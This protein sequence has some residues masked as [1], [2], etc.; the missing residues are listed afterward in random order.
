[1]KQIKFAMRYVARHWWQ[2][3]LGILALYLVDQIN[4]MMEKG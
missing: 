2:Y 1:M 3:A 4:H